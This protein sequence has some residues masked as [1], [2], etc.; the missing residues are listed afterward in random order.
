MSDNNA[1]T[2]YLYKNGSSIHEGGE[3]TPGNAQTTEVSAMLNLAED[4]YIQVYG[5]QNSNANKN[6]VAGTAS[7]FFGFKL[8]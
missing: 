5:A 4:D 1:M 7:Q 3:R 6:I 8:V 2:V